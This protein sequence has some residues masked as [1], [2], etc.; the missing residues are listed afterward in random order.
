MRLLLCIALVLAIANADVYL[1]YPRGSNNRLDEANRGR[2][3]GNRLFDS[4]NN[5]RGG[6][7]VG[8]VYYYTGT[9][10][11]MEWTNQHSCGGPNNH[12]ELIIQYACDDLIRDG[13]TTNTI[14]DTKSADTDPQFGRHESWNFYNNGCKYRSRN[15]G[16]FTANQNLQGP[17]ARFTRQNPNNNR[18]G[19][20]CPEERDYYPYWHPTMW[21]DVAILT[22]QPQRC[23]AYRGESQ[24]VKP[25]YWCKV[26]SDW[27]TD[28]IN[29]GRTGFIPINQTECE[30]ITALWERDPI[31]N[32]TVRGQWLAQAPWNI[33][34]PDCVENHWSRDN[35]LGNA[36]GGNPLS[37]NWT[38]PNDFTHERCVLRLRYNIST[39]EFQGWESVDGVQV[40]DVD[41]KYNNP[42]NQQNKDPALVNVWSKYG[43]NWAEVNTSFAR[44]LNDPNGAAVKASRGYVLRNDPTVDIFGP[45]LIPRDQGTTAQQPSMIRL[46]VALDTSQYGRTFEDRTHR[47]AIRSRPSNLNGV[48]IHNVHVRG[49]RGNI[50]QTFPGT[51][52][53]FFPKRLDVRRGDY[54]HFQWTGSNTNPDNNAGQGKAGTDRH[55]VVLLRGRSYDEGQPNGGLPTFGQWGSN[56]PS[57]V[58]NQTEGSFLGFSL[59]DMKR[60]ATLQASPQLGGNMD[61][62]D[63]AATYFDLGPRQATKNGI[64]HYVS[65]RSNNFSNRDHKAKITVSDSSVTS[66]T[67]STGRMSTVNFGNGVSVVVYP[68]SFSRVSSATLVSTPSDARTGFKGSPSSEYQELILTEPIAAGGYITI[69]IP[70][71]DK[72]LMI[73]QMYRADNLDSS[74]W[75]SVSASYSGGV[76][77]ADVTQGGVYVVESQPNWGAIVGIVIG[78]LAVVAGAAAAYYYF[79]V[80]KPRQAGAAVPSSPSAEPTK[81]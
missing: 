11:N 24:N 73:N 63:D 62:L 56:Y 2:N 50:V 5:N 32:E 76:A 30:R 53:D 13:T 44:N 22:N 58:T 65:T 51:E 14:P 57:M 39:T 49:K 27:Q 81:V 35:H 21:R 54:V 75:T 67:L 38:L 74:S 18:R 80:Y 29:R 7:N 61:E 48:K 37:Y 20:E 43:L 4:Q 40:G 66:Q 36:V 41:S 23:D 70:Y 25:K 68:S 71:E 31:T 60:L 55:N 79:K 1:Q 47:F 59:E 26:P 78:A 9:T 33:P 6:Y 34:P 42:T 16:L 12:C 46:Q 15:R 8:S 77:T 19:Y 17:D 69:S 64:Y 10:M 45:A 52:Y 72:P 3:N 28:Q